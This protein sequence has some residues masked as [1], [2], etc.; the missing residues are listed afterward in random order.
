MSGPGP[1]LSLATARSVSTASVPDYDPGELGTG[2]VHLG[3]GA[4][5]RAHQAVFTDAAT[6]ITDGGWGIVGVTQR[7]TRVLEQLRPQDGLFT[8]VTA[9]GGAEVQA[10]IVGSVRAVV[11]AQSEPAALRAAMGAAGTRI[12]SM[13]VTEKGYAG[14][15]STGM[16]DTLNPLVERDLTDIEPHRS[17]IG[18]LVGAFQQRAER[19]LGG[20][21]VLCCDNVTRGGDLVREL[22]GQFLQHSPLGAD[23]SLTTW[24]QANVRFPNTLVDRIVPETPAAAV[25]ALGRQLGYRDDGL[26]CAET[27]GLWVIEDHFAAGHPRWPDENVHLVD[28]VRPWSDLKLRLVNGGHSLLAYLGL[29]AG[30]R[31]VAEVMTGPTFREMLTAWLDEASTSLPNVPAGVDLSAYR[32][33]ITERFANPGL[34]YEL[35]KI[36][37]DGSAKLPIRIGST[38]ADLIDRGAPARLCALVLAGWIAYA[39]SDALTDPLADE[40]RRVLDEE[41]DAGGQV[42]RLFSPAGVV[43]LPEVLAGG[44]LDDVSTA[45]VS[46]RRSGGRADAEYLR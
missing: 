36:A 46:L 15:L 3:I 29:L 40:I 6:D 30:Y 16:L 24:I 9:S 8:V 12:V 27:Y 31:T 25:A 20:V 4:F 33:Q 19:G 14:D 22:C 35:T 5:H 1:R 43:A 18:Q 37:A 44:F 32:T 13:T 7:S 45:L 28:D 23:G 34:A 21:T 17:V 2:I 42:Q 10:R 26:V 11:S 39:S 41:P 38:A